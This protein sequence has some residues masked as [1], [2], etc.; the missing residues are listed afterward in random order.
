[1]LSVLI[2]ERGSDK[3]FYPDSKEP[4]KNYASL[5]DPFRMQKCNL[6]WNKARV[7]LAETKLE[8]LYSALKVQDKN[9]LTLKKLKS[10]G[11]DKEGLKEDEMRK[12]FNNIML[13]F[14]LGGTQVSKELLIHFLFIIQGNDTGYTDTL[15]FKE[16]NFISKKQDSVYNPSNAIFKDKKLQRLWEKAEQAGLNSEELLALQEEFR[17]HQMKVDEYHSLLENPDKDL[18]SS[19]NEIKKQNEKQI[20]LRDSN[21]ISKKGK[22]IK[23]NYDRL[24]RLA[25]NQGEEREFEET[26]V[27]GLW[28]LALNSNFTSLELESIRE[29][30]VG[31]SAINLIFIIIQ[32]RFIIKKD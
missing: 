29:E 3:N 17:H 32:F 4:I 10:E 24:H 1:M 5:D 26:K 16:G 30:L 25:T 27:A 2:S 8:H 9:E 15:Y 11:H 12:K 23:S 7:K 18:D 14:G 20:D 19:Y 28:K 22:E 6:L 31:Y 13:S 21:E